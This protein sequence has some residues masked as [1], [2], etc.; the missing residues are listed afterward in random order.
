MRRTLT[1]ITGAAQCAPR[2]QARD[3][4]GIVELIVREGDDQHRPARAQG[5]RGRADAALM[6][7]G[8]GAGKHRGV[9]R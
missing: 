4:G 3:A 1:G 8:G 2:A 6:N 9:G 5:L 7:D